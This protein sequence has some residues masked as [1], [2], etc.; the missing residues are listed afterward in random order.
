MF[1]CIQGISGKR[2]SFHMYWAMVGKEIKFREITLQLYTGV[3]LYNN[4]AA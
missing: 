1:P 2:A 4:A 3:F